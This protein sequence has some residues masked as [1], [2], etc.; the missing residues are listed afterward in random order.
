MGCGSAKPTMAGTSAFGCDAESVI[1]AVRPSPSCPI[2]SLRRRRSACIADNRPVRASPQVIPLNKQRRT[3]KIRRARPILPLCADGHIG[4]CSACTPG[5]G[6]EPSAITFCGRPPSLPGIWA[7]SAVFCRSR[8]EVRES[9]SSRRLKRTDSLD[10]LSARAGLAS[11]PATQP[12]PMNG[13]VPFASRSQP[14]LPGG[15]QQKPLLLLRLWPR[16]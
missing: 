4:V 12:G 16:R 3:A 1:P 7:L 13:A 6:P 5:G 2:G 9:R 10:G 15:W 11:G 8:Q 14:K